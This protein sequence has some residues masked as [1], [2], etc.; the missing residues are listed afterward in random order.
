VH[1]DR[2]GELADFQIAAAADDEQRII[3]GIATTPRPDRSGDV[4]D[5]LGATFT[6]PVP[7]L[8]G[9]DK[10]LPVGEVVFG[11][12]TPAGV[13][14]T[15]TLPKILEP[16]PLKDRVDGAWQAIKARLLKSVSP[17]YRALR[18]AITP[19]AF[20][21]CNFLKTEFLELSLV[22][23]P[24]NADATITTY[25]AASPDTKPMSTIHEQITH[26]TNERAPLVTRMHEMLSPEKTLTEIEQQQYDDVAGRVQAINGQLDRLRVAEAANVG[27][28]MPLA[29]T[30][31]P[32]HTKSITPIRVM[33]NLPKG[34]LFVRATCASVI[35][36]GNKH[37]AALYAEQRWPDH[38]E[39]AMFLKAAVAPGTATDAT[40]AGP[41]VSTTVADE[42][43]ALLRPATAIGRITGLRKVPFNTK[44]PAQ[45]GGGTY[46]WVGEGK[47]K[48]VTKLAFT[49]TT[50]P[51]HKSAGI[52]V[53]TE[54]LARLSNPDA[55]D[56]ARAD[57]IAGIATF[58]DSQFID[59]AS[60]AVAGVKPASVTNGVTPIA[61]I[62]PL[63][64]LVAIANAFTTANVPLAGLTYVMSPGNALVLA[65]Q[66]DNNNQLRFPGMTAEGGTV[67]GLNVVTSGAAGTNVIG[68]IPSLI[69][70][71]D[72]GGVTVDVSNQ[73][74]LQMSDSPMDPADATTVFMSLW[75]N[76]MVGLRAEWFIS[77]LKA[78]AQAVK[79][80][81]NA[82]YVIPTPTGLE[83]MAVPDGKTRNGKA[84]D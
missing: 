82:T 15:A 12:P 13:P 72:G 4:L 71:G 16:G 26:W 11:P 31:I 19:N 41:L 53:I 23:V 49:S 83:A 55:E 42:F 17:G 76:N 29:G 36:N 64:D 70:Y 20:G 21:G 37:E 51:M 80:V 84:A 56:V 61:S 39:I 63:N 62:G 47:P 77:W 75:Q 25:K 50:L 34:Q 8:L 7:L 14:F 18:D 69:L 9:H 78:N 74:S 2:T 67:A 10:N 3:T 52:I 60:A 24:A 57:M 22:T 65:F 32:M 79:Y 30:P 66:R 59:P 38:P 73:A 45:S 43:I 40:W 33:P 28:A 68:L 46:G 6:N 48:P 5:P 58:V 35:C 27:K 54:E 1:T 44:V 81:N